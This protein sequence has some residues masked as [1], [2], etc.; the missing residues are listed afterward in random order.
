M[1]ANLDPE[2]VHTL[3]LEGKVDERMGKDGKG[4]VYIVDS[5]DSVDA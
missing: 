4:S 5:V 1:R 3:A 2:T